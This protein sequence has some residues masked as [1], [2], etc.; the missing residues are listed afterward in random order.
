MR[1]VSRATDLLVR[2]RYPGSLPEEVAETLGIEIANFLNF[3]KIVNLLTSSGCR[4]TTL[5]RFMARQNAERVFEKAMRK[6][7]FTNSSMFSFY[8]PEGWLVFELQFD[9]EERLRCLYVHHKL[10]DYPQGFEL[11]LAEYDLK[12]S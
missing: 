7:C 12:S 3:K 6:E 4:P 8:F 10:I 9:H 11:Q 2:L 1:L 5:H